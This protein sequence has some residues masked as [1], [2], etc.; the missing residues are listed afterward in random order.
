MLVQLQ[1]ERFRRYRPRCVVAGTDQGVARAEALA[2]RLGLLSNGT[3]L[4]DVRRDK[5]LTAELLRNRWLNAPLQFRAS[6]PDSAAAW[7]REHPEIKKWVVKPTRSAGG[8]RVK[9]CITSEEVMAAVECIVEGTNVFGETDDSAVIQEFLTSSADEN[10]Y[11]V[12]TCSMSHPR[13]GEIKHRVVSI[14]RYEKI[15]VNG[16]A[17]VYYARHILPPQGGVQRKLTS[18]VIACL[19]ALEIRSGPCHAELRITDRGPALVE[20]NVGRPDGGGVPLLDATCTGTDQVTLTVESLLA[21]DEKWDTFDAEY[22]LQKRG[23]LAFF[24]SRSFGELRGIPGLQLLRAL[25]SFLD[26]IFLAKPGQPL[27]P[28]I[29]VTTLLGW[30]FLANANERVLEDDY[31]TL[32]NLER[33]GKI[34]DIIA[35]SDA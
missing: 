15:E 24:I 16:A 1:E 6:T 4:S 21:P 11:V 28:T 13:T 17:F 35:R 18:Y 7:V 29:D 20:A 26:A 14:Y 3:Q 34:F 8:D 27:V 32:R 10:E 30:V 23:R 5:Y 2:E 9:S 12:N 31:Q 33:E 25:P 19:D 22:Q